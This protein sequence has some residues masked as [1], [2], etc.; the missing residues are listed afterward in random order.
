MNKSK[1]VILIILI[2][3]IYF[4]FPNSGFGQVEQTF[5]KEQ[6]FHGFGFKINIDAGTKVRRNRGPDFDTYLFYFDDKPILQIY[7]GNHPNILNQNH[8]LI[9]YLSNGLQFK[10]FDSK[11]R[12]NREFKECLIDLNNYFPNYLHLSYNKN[13]I[14]LA[15]KLI[16]SIQKSDKPHTIEIKIDRGDPETP[17]HL[18]ASTGDL[19]EAKMLISNGADINAIAL[20]MY[21]PLHY[22]VM[23]GNFEML[24]YLISKGAL[25][26][27]RKHKTKTPITPL[28][29]LC[30]KFKSENI[31]IAEYL[32]KSGAEINAKNPEG[33]TP[34]LTAIYS[35][36]LE[37]LQVL[38]NHG[39]NHNAKEND[40]DTALH[41]AVRR[42]V[43][44][45]DQKDGLTIVKFFIDAGL[46]VDAKNEDGK[47][48][49]DIVENVKE[50]QLREI[51][52]ARQN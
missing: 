3:S 21:S 10:C 43:Y 41:L 19:D 36:Q 5:A 24:K 35:C 20:H 16:Y 1:K 49:W 48:I 47:S 13:E 2:V 26:N 39:A 51:V 52:N 28:H 11:G 44:R 27:T 25:V 17:L 34:L 30:G 42:W 38:M 31:R 14:N 46:D 45:D 33:S 7:S 6:V 4:L 23:E 8:T 50:K 18:S 22:A 15:E 32:I 29:M 40:G 12:K 37:V 9:E